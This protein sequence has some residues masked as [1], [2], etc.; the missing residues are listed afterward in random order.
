MSAFTDRL[1]TQW[2]RQNGAGGQCPTVSE[3]TL[4]PVWPPSAAMWGR[5]T[6]LPPFA[7]HC[8]SPC[9]ESLFHLPSIERISNEINTLQTYTSWNI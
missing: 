8:A 3:A 5:W 7:S 9:L 1:Y 4:T 6:R 2:K